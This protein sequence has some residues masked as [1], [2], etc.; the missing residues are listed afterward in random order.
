MLLLARSRTMSS[1]PLFI[2]EARNKEPTH[3]EELMMTTVNH[4][5]GRN[6]STVFS[7]RPRSSTTTMTA[8][9]AITAKG[10][11]RRANDARARN[12]SLLAVHCTARYRRKALTTNQTGAAAKIKTVSKSPNI[13]VSTPACSRH[14]AVSF[15]QCFKQCILQRACAQRHISHAN[16]FKI[17]GNGSPGKVQSE[18][19]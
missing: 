17:D 5:A 14:S 11:K 12:I 4:H 7:G 13:T 10:S 16:P 8:D 19:G 1:L 9:P 18:G 15:A 2:R 3:T 6:L